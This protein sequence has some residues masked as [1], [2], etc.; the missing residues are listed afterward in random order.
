M[1]GTVCHDHCTIKGL[2]TETTND[3]RLATCNAFDF[4]TAE[5]KTKFFGKESS[6]PP[7]YEEIPCNSEDCG[8][9]A[10]GH[11]YW[12]YSEKALLNS[13]TPEK[14]LQF[15]ENKELKIRENCWSC[16][17]ATSCTCI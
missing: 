16:D 17:T 4:D 9:H 12:N 10:E 11:T 8:D 6:E 7:G 2:P 3:E 15:E 5:A 1:Y 13:L 14:R